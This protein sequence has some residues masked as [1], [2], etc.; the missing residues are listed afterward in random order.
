MVLFYPHKRS[1]TP[2]Y[3]YAVDWYARLTLCET[4]AIALFSQAE[5]R[6]EFV[7]TPVE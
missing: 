6:P 1:P 2:G 3:A 7:S 4:G 5:T